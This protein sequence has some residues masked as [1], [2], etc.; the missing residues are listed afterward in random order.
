MT[1]RTLLIVYALANSALYSLLLP[2]WEGFDEPFHF[3]YSQSLANGYGLPDPRTARLS[4]EVGESLLLAPASHV[5]KQNL[6]DVTTY[7]Q[8]FALPLSRQLQLR[9]KL[10][11]IPAEWRWQPSRFLNYEAHHPPL[12]Y[13]LLAFPERL[14]AGLA[15][16]HRVAV[17][18]LFA[19][20]AGSLLLLGGANRLF[21]QLG[22]QGPWKTAALFCLL[23]CQMTWAT[24]ARVSNDWLAVPLAVWTLVA[25]N[26][27]G[28][29]PSLRASTNAAVLFATA[30][31][32]KAYFLAL[33]PLL[34]VPFVWRRRWSDLSVASAIVCVLAGPWYVRNVVRYGVLT[35]TQESRA[36]ID[37]PMV[38]HSFQTLDWSAVVLSSVRSSIWTGNNSFLTFSATTLNVMSATGLLALLLWAVGSHSRSEWITFL[39]CVLFLLALSYAAVVS[40]IYTHGTATGPSPWYAQAMSAPIAGLAFL[41]ASRS[42][43]IGTIV[44]AALMSLSGY[45]IAVTYVLKLI[46]LYGGYEGR[47]SLTGVLFSDRSLTRIAANL[48]RIVLAPPILVYALTGLVVMLAIVQIGIVIRSLV[49]QELEPHCL[50]SNRSRRLD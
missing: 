13:A 32:T 2:L 33:L 30:L 36:G 18:R 3:A 15:L 28:A 14:L 9:D 16:R 23:S 26:R 46:P 24:L 4:R 43:W 50:P 40:H 49:R 47:V 48:D 44:A 21:R 29:S 38:V 41:G 8:F 25:L 7:A 22:I 6:P 20:T 37:L 11:N 34:P 31:L 35:G 42:K 1:A 10:R 45:V 12:A 39:F 19:A 5:V 27:Y 17:L